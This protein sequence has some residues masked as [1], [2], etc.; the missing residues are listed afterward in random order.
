[1]W[2]CKEWWNIQF[3]LGIWCGPLSQHP[4]PPARHQPHLLIPSAQTILKTSTISHVKFHTRD[5][6]VRDAHFPLFKTYATFGTPVLFHLKCYVRDKHSLSFKTWV[7]FATCIL[8]HLKRSYCSQ[9]AI[10]FIQNA[11]NVHHKHSHYIALCT[12]W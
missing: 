6:G 5:R 12:S 4:L 9:R 8:F 2:K 11:R 3:T 1:M 7:M 10:S